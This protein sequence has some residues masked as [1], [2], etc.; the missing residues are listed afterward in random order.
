ME[1]KDQLFFV[2][3]GICVLL[4]AVLLLG[5]MLGNV[6][7]HGPGLHLAGQPPRFLGV[8][9]EAWADLHQFL[10][11]CFVLGAALHVYLNWAWVKSTVT[12]RFGERSRT[13]LYSLLGAPVA[14]VILCWIVLMI[15]S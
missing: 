13:F 7:P 11:I 3:A 14:L 15:A 10:A 12:Q 8:E 1:K 5:L 6:I 9:R 4:G 2:N